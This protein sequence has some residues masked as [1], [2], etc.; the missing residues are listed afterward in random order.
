ML[1]LFIERSRARRWSASVARA[2][3]LFL[4][5]STLYASTM[6]AQ[7]AARADSAAEA[8][9][10]RYLAR[11]FAMYPSRATQAGNRRFDHQLERFSAAE[12]TEWTALNGTVVEESGRWLG[13]PPPSGSSGSSTSER[14]SPGSGLRADVRLDLEVVRAQAEREW[15]EFHTR[16]RPE[17]DPLF[18]SQTV[19]ES[20]IFLLVRDDRPLGERMAAVRFRMRHLPALLVEARRVLATAAD[21]LVV[22]EFALGAARQVRAGATFYR[23]GIPRFAAPLERDVV[24]ATEREGLQAAQ[25]LEQFALF[26]DTLAA[27]ATGSARLGADY[28]EVFRVGTGVRDPVDSVLARAERDLL[29]TRAE[30]ATYARQHWGEI[31]PALPLPSDDRS[32]VAAAFEQVAAQRD[33]S[34]T[35]YLAYW[36]SLPDSLEAFIREYDIA[37]LPLPRTLRVDI[38]PPMLAGQSVGGVYPAGPFSPDAP[39]ILYIPVPGDGA[40]REA[41]DVFFRDF[42]RPFTRMIAA[43]ELLPGHYAQLKQSARHPRAVRSVFADGV[44]TEGWGTFCERI[45]L[46]AGWGGPLPFLAH[47]KKAMENIA[48]T[49]VDIRVHTKGMTREA[50]VR[51]VRDDA[52]QGE[53]LAANMWTRTLTTAPQITTYYLGSRQIRDIFEAVRAREGAAFSLHAFMDAMVAEG[54]VP[55]SALRARLL[56]P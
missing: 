53:Q 4:L 13:I 47:Y 30:A 24:R 50:M 42:N 12:R 55:V 22:A 2:A 27:R 43:H 15:F 26:L 35:E 19:G 9:V 20:V 51:F 16:R 39:T 5:A 32:V 44:F 38:A 56:E 37:T 46:D 6:L 48:R 10:E 31:A 8:L 29:T 18:W 23:D 21:S 7:S 34:V 14:Q 54:S 17:R 3:A 41:S 52:L 11:Y 40:T 49:I 1:S 25:A 33:T 28:A 36:R 45:M